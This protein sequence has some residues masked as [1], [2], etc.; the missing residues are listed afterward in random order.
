[1]L[2][3]LEH[4][5][6]VFHVSQITNY[7]LDSDHAIITEPIGGVEDLMYKECPSQRLD[8]RIKQLRN[9]QI[10]LVKLLWTNHTSAKAT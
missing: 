3:E 5:H 2:I 1:M 10:P 6:N 4:V 8:R 7:I 9:K